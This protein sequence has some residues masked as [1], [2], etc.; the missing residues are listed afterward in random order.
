MVLNQNGKAENGG[1]N[2][3]FIGRFQ[4]L[5]L[6][7]L[8]A[9]GVLS[10]QSHSVTI[11]IGSAQYSN[12]PENPFSCDERRRMIDAALSG[13]GIAN[14]SIVPID[15]L[16]DHSRWVAYVVS[17][18]PPFSAVHS[19]DPLTK[20]LF[21]KAGYSVREV[22]YLNRDEFMGTEVRRRL[23]VGLEWERLV[24]REVAAIIRE[25]GGPARLSGLVSGGKGK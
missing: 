7:H 22:D 10:T 19:N 20:R 2:A 15:D 1:G 4:P 9:V 16:N 14:Y 23:A 6:G 5:H 13:A 11:G 24:P 21:E 8:H 3:L 25:I 12:T 17:L 18:V